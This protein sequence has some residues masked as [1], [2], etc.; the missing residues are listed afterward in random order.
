MERSENRSRSPD[1][2]SPKLGSSRRK[3][4]LE[5]RREY[6][7]IEREQRAKEAFEYKKEISENSSDRRQ[8]NF[9]PKEFNDREWGKLHAAIYARVGLY[10]DEII[11]GGWQGGAK[12]TKENS[13][14]FAAEVL[15]YVRN[16]FYTE[17]A[18]VEAEF[19]AAGY[20][21]KR[22]PP[23]GP[24]THKLV[25][26]DMKWVCD[27][28]I[29]PV[30][31]QYSNELFLCN[32]CE[33]K[34]RL[35]TLESVLQHYASKHTNTLSKG[36]VVVHWRAEWPENPPFNPE[37]DVVMNTFHFVGPSSTISANGPL[38]SPRVLRGNSEIRELEKKKCEQEIREREIQI[39]EAKE[40][41]ERKER[42]KAEK[43]YESK[44][45][46]TRAA[47]AAERKKRELADQTAAS[48]KPLSDSQRG[49]GGASSVQRN[50]PSTSQGMS[51]SCV[52]IF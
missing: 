43:E 10:A 35:Y 30:T 42:E 15:L 3:S 1:R 32:G 14:R 5:K 13:P 18:K 41:I 50:G 4:E 38:T 26:E 8:P 39:K 46:Q 52:D 48:K 19:R 2:S 44:E 9:Q 31:D 7:N 34:N 28:K 45:R 25:L 51:L 21:P 49:A 37:P 22:D 23:S 47:E 33:H 29:K 6:E 27:T 17:I 12:V 40:K 36:T 16:K 20:E 11:R 24:S